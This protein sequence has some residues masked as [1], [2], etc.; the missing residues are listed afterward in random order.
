MVCVCVCVFGVLNSEVIIMMCAYVR[1]CVCVCVCVCVCACVR[2]C[3]CC[4]F[5]Y[6]VDVWFC[7]FFRFIVLCPMI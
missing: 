1:M 2:V 4:T 7:G 5:F 6:H 3:V